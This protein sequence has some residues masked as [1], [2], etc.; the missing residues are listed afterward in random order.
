MPVTR[1][2]GVTVP[3]GSDSYALTNDLSK[4]ADTSNVATVIH[5]Q[6]ERDNLTPFEGMIIVRMDKKGLRETYIDTEWV[7][8]TGWLEAGITVSP[9]WQQNGSLLYRI[10]GGIQ[11]HLRGQ[12]DRTGGEIVI[13]SPTGNIAN[14]EVVTLPAALWPVYY[15]GIGSSFLGRSASFQV[16]SEGGVDVVAVAAPNA[17]ITTGESLSFS[18]VYLLD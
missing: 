9:G 4:M 18:G 14:T 17:N 8:D 3:I 10:V 12:M 7:G 11:V 15:Q 16:T 2:N 13:N 1:Q 5:S 6:T